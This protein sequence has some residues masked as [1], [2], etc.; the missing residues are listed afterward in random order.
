[1][2][3]AKNPGAAMGGKRRPERATSA[4]SRAGVEARIERIEGR[5]AESSVLE[6]YHLPCRWRKDKNAESVARYA[7]EALKE[8]LPCWSG[9]RKRCGFASCGSGAIA[10]RAAV[11]RV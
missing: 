4:I 3:Q 2:P 11:K 6:E 7:F 5:S 8:F 10:E 9:R 1:M